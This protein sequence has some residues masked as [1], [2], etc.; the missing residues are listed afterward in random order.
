[1]IN[2]FLNLSYNSL[3]HRKLRTLLTIIGIVIGISAIVSLLA[4]SQGLENS[5]NEQFEQ[6]GPNRIFIFPKGQEFSFSGEEGLTNKDIDAIEKLSELEWVNPWLV[7]SEEVKFGNEK[8]FAQNIIALPAKDTEKRLTDFGISLEK[9]RFFSNNEK[10]SI[11]IG[12]RI[13]HNFFDREV[14]VN[15]KLKIKDKDFR[16]ISI[17]SEIGNQEDDSTIYMVLEDARDLF[18]KPNEVNFIEVKIKNGFDINSI[19]DKLQRK[20]EKSRDDDL[21]TIQTPEQIL[22]DINSVLGILQIVLGSIAAISLLVGAIGITN[23]MFT[24]TLE[25]TKDIGIMKSLGAKNS[26]ILLIFLL[27]SAIIGLIGG[28]LGVIVGSLIALGVGQA[29]AAGGFGLLKIII[30]YKI[31]LLGLGFAVFVSVISGI[32]PAYKASKLKPVEA[33]KHA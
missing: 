7:A 11:M 30:S 27:E 6:I 12:H 22:E 28:V 31:I 2:D 23:S 25:R 20:L 17:I 15:S 18:Q 4:L 10:G 24:S 29:A 9:G 3:K 14:L 13:A 21:F 19:A 8:G 16:V 26:H 1:M 5:I 33:L 32:T